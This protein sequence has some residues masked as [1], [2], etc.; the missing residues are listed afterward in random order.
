M[1]SGVV[2][3]GQRFFG[4]DLKAANLSP[5]FFTRSTGL[6]AGKYSINNYVPNPILFNL[7]ELMLLT[8]LIVLPIFFKFVHSKTMST[9]TK[10]MKNGF[11][12]GCFI[13]VTTSCIN[14]MVNVS[15]IGYYNAFSITS[16][17]ISLLILIYFSVEIWKLIEP[18]HKWSF[19]FNN[20]EAYLSFDCHPN[21][22]PGTKFSIW[23]YI[24]LA[25]FLA[26]PILTYPLSNAG[27][28]S[29]IVF[30]VFQI[31]L[32]YS[33]TKNLSNN[34]WREDFGLFTFL[35][36]NG[37]FCRIMCGLIMLI[38]W[39]LPK[40]LTLFW[41]KILT[42]V[43]VFF[44]LLDL[45]LIIGESIAR[46]IYLI[47]ESDNKVKLKEYKPIKLSAAKEKYIPLAERNKGY[48]SISKSKDNK[49]HPSEG[50]NQAP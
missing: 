12:I 33:Y 40:V 21:S 16:V 43:F 7:W 30:T 2:E 39:I 37:A 49:I 32:L 13:P 50:V 47:L 44:Y 5:G 27:V 26:L 19:F 31:V 38:M 25:I 41:I 10:R 22:I 20:E 42:W 34:E 28:A 1:L 14:C 35:K 11:L 9:I 3:S 6:W 24:P 36:I 45:L 4:T 29:P 8:I 48:E 23:E 18:S 15:W 17:S 46:Y